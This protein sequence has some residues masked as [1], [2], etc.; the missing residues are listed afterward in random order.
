LRYRTRRAPN[1]VIAMVIQDRLS[2]RITTTGG[3]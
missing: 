3:C 2:V 1:P